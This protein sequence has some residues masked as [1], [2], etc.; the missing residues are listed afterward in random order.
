MDELLSFSQLIKSLIQDNEILDIKDARE[1]V[2]TINNF[3]YTN[4]ESIGHT[5]ALGNT[6]EYL[7]DFHKYWEKNHAKILDCQIN[8]DKCELVADALHSVFLKTKGSAF[9]EIFHTCGLSPKDICRVR[10]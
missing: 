4:Y 7:S 3:L 6:Y 1:I 8:D 10:F 5:K 9:Q 2:K